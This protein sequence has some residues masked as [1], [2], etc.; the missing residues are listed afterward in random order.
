MFKIFVESYIMK[1]ILLHSITKSAL[2]I[3]LT[4]QSICAMEPE[5]PME[6]ELVSKKRSNDS[7]VE[8]ESKY[9]KQRIEVLSIE[10]L[11]TKT[12]ELIVDF[13]HKQQISFKTIS[14]VCKK[15]KDL[16][17]KI[18]HSVFITNGVLWEHIWD[19]KLFSL[20]NRFKNIRFLDLTNN[21]TASDTGL[22]R[23]TALTSLDLRNSLMITDAGIKTFTALTSLDLCYT[24]K[25]TN[26]GI[27]HL[28][29]LI[30]LGLAWNN[31]ITDEGITSL[32]ALT[33]LNLRE[34]KTITNAGITPLTNLAILNLRDNR[35]ITDPGITP[36]TNLAILNLFGNDM[37]SY[38][39]IKQLP[40]CI[41]SYDDW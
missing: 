7:A 33:N 20:S 34:N 12:L 29:N 15:W 18:T 21:C 27:K 5:F 41:I 8:G 32:T 9:K 37:I 3:G 31:T 25:I 39:G 36:L 10:S 38:A 1:K 16:S 26:D 19:H 30:S 40:N 28:T 23:F 6:T 24:H 22:T 4:V 2:G 14:V 17:D 35:S 11:P 13:G